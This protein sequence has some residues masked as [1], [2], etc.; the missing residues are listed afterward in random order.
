MQKDISAVSSLS[1][2]SSIPSLAFSYAR[3]V[4]FSFFFVSC[5]SSRSMP[6]VFELS[7]RRSSP[8]KEIFSHLNNKLAYRDNFVMKRNTKNVSRYRISF[9]FSKH[10]DIHICS[11]VGSSFSNNYSTRKL[12]ED[13]EQASSN[14]D[15]RENVSKTKSCCHSSAICSG[16]L[17]CLS[18]ILT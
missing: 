1:R 16:D 10:T 9:V 8:T 14:D 13:R 4:L 12:E 11:V 5:L 2:S 17:L 18:N 15:S 7:S 6:S 3:R